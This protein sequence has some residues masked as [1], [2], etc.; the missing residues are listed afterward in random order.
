M[1]KKQILAT[2]GPEGTYSERAS[3]KYLAQTGQDDTIIEYHE[4]ILRVFEAVG[5]TA[6][7]AVV[8][9]ENL[10]VGFVPQTLEGFLAFP[11]TII[12]EVLLSIQF[13][14]LS[15]LPLTE[16]THLF[17]Q[18]VAQEQCSEFIKN[19]PK[20]VHIIPTESNI[21]SYQLSACAPATAAIA[22]IYL[23]HEKAQKYKNS[24]ENVADY[25]HNQT[26]FVVIAPLDTQTDCPLP[27]KTSIVV[28][29]SSNHSGILRDIT[30]A[31]SSHNIN[32]TSIASRPTRQTLGKYHFFI[33]F[34]GSIQAPEVC[35]A[36]EEIRQRYPVKILGCFHTQKELTV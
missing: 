5:K 31:F 6:E 4:T 29:D 16:V 36:L 1:S 8:P 19:L 34:E 17:V 2:L 25:S 28:S 24:I 30:V 3:R 22:P 11:C 14:C 18:K 10:S 23:F 20:S 27:C 15:Q 26:R 32:M 35:A 9:I 12:E 33:D 21:E 7:K 13:S